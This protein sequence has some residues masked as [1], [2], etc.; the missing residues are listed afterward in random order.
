MKTKTRDREGKPALSRRIAKR[1]CCALI[2]CLTL[3]FSAHGQSLVQADEAREVNRFL[4]ESAQSHNSLPCQIHGQTRAWL[5][6][7]LRY[8]SGFSIECRLGQIQLGETLQAF[9]RIK[10]Q[11]GQAVLMK[12]EFDVPSRPQQRSAEP[13]SVKLDDMSISMSGWFAVGEGSYSVEMLLTDPQHHTSRKAWA[14]KAGK[15]DQARTL[16]SALK[17]GEVAPPSAAPW[18]G[19]LDSKGMRLTVLLHVDS[20][21]A[22]TMAW[23]RAIVL[24]SLTSLLNQTPCREV[25]VVAF[26]LDQAREIFREERFDADGFTKLSDALEHLQMGTVAYQAL[27]K[28]AWQEFLI[29]V[30][31]EEAATKEPAD[32]VIFLGSGTHFDGAPPKPALHDIEGSPVHFFDFRYF[33]DR[34]PDGVSRL[35]KSLNG[36]LFEID[37]P[38]DLDQAI[39]KMLDEIR[40]AK[41]GQPTSSTAGDSIHSN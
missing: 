24:Q 6:F 2:V 34:V 33:S 36:S 19:K 30:V 3:V 7:V 1:T 16:A 14:F 4:D 13:N 10:P 37:S 5:D 39:R 27:E 21:G 28:R 35:T 32:A 25:R 11:D 9:I 41:K 18:S 20:Y 17:P 8:G 23:Y 38:G 12:E 26:S 29:K 22:E 31:D 15:R 40:S